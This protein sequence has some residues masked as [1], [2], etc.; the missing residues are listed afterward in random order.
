MSLQSRQSVTEANSN[1]AVSPKIQRACAC[2]AQ[3]GVSGKCGSCATNE[4]L[5]LGSNVKIGAA[6]DRYEQEADLI[7]EQVVSGQSLSAGAGLTV[8]PLLQRQSLEDEE[9]ELQM[10]AVP[11][12]SNGADKTL[13]RQP[14]E[15]EE[16][17]L[18]PKTA[19]GSLQTSGAAQAAARAVSSGGRPLSSAMRSYFEPRFGT[20]LSAVRIHDEPQ[21]ATAARA[22]NARAYTLANHIAFAPGELAPQTQDGRRLM[23]HELVHTLQQSRGGVIRRAPSS[24]AQAPGKAGAKAG[25]GAGGPMAASPHMKLF[26]AMMEMCRRSDTA[27]ILN[28]IDADNVEIRFFRKATDRWR[29]DDGTIEEVDLSTRLGGNTFIDP[30]TKHGIIRIN[31]RLSERKMVEVLFHEMQHWIHRQS[32][33]GPRGLESEIQA[34]IATEQMAIDRG[35]PETVKGYRTADGQVNEAFIRQQMQASPHYSPKGRTRI[36]GG[37]TYDGETVVP[38]P[39]ACPPLGDFPMPRSDQAYA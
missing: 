22:I 10:K 35:W 5:G 2:G 25:G 39:F 7:A 17:M 11:G 27:S 12:S 24:Q 14:E 33:T 8:S 26:M 21:A 1:P 28:R 16:E 18:Q 34:R 20:D 37:R 30:K 36:P 38:G 19:G 23:A 31:E 13:Q 6:N 4:K 15:E 3:A 32:P 9:D 29:L